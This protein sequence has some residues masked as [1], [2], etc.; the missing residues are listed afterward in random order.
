MRPPARPLFTPAQPYHHHPPQQQPPQPQAV[1]HQRKAKFVDVNGVAYQLIRQIGSGGS[2]KV[3]QAADFAKQRLVAIKTVDLEGIDR[4]MIDSYRNE[5]TILEKLQHSNRVV[6]LIDHETNAE[7]NLLYIVMECGACDLA[8]ILNE[9]VARKNITRNLVRF[10]WEE[11]LSC[12]AVIHA[13]DV[14]H[15]DLKPANFL[16]VDGTLKLIDFGIANAIQSDKT[17][18]TRDAQIG[19]LNYMSPEAIIDMGEEGKTR[20]KIGTKSDV[21]SLGCILYSMV[22]AKTPFHHLTNYVRKLQAI[23]DPNSN[24]EFGDLPDKH[25]LDVMRKCLNRDPKARPSVD[26]LL[27][28]PYLWS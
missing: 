19:T 18:V 16:V 5:I 26:Q 22:Y 4:A 14:V 17:S 20:I 1:N 2:C 23:I 15:S 8:T 25:L 21:W 6:K 24:I 12:I 10:Y 13:E 7:N 3:H 27:A 11:M 9:R 28:H